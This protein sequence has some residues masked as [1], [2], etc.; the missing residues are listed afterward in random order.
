MDGLGE[1]VDLLLGDD[2]H[3]G[4]PVGG[5]DWDTDREETLIRRNQN[6]NGAYVAYFL[7]VS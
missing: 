2:E 4:T 6:T 7:D 5:L 3:K 1:V